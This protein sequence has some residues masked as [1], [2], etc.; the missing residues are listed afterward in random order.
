MHLGCTIFPAKRYRLN[1]LSKTCFLSVNR[2]ELNGNLMRM[3]LLEVCLEGA[4]LMWM[5]DDTV[6]NLCGKH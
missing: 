6:S 1:S 5:K 2:F 4:I 3:Q